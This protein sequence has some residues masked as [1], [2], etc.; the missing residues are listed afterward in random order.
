MEGQRLRMGFQSILMI[1]LGNYN[2][3][4]TDPGE[5]T[6]GV[7]KWV[8]HE[9]YHEYGRHSYDIAIIQLKR[10]VKFNKYVDTACLPMKTEY[11]DDKTVLISGWGSTTQKNASLLSKT[12][13][14]PSAILQKASVKILNSRICQRMYDVPNQNGNTAKIDDGMICAASEGKDACQ[15]DSGGIKLF[16]KLK[17]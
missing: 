6:Y 16:H 14:S 13:R 12:S 1:V 4:Q 2:L 7:R 9:Y 5:V 8:I 10:K 15:G 11:A 3:Y 17:L